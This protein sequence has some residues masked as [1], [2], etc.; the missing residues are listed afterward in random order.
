LR[1]VFP[2]RV[3]ANGALAVLADTEEGLETRRFL[4]QRVREP[5]RALEVSPD[6]AGLEGWRVVDFRPGPDGGVH[7]LEFLENAGGDWLNRLRHVNSA[8]ATTWSRQGEVDFQNTAPDRLAG[9]YTGLHQGGDGRLWLV[10]KA[11]TA[12]L[13]AIAPSDGRTLAVARLDA[14]ISNLVVSADDQA[15]YARMVERQGE[16]A[17]VLATTDLRTGRTTLGEPAS[18][19]LLDLAG[20]DARGRVY[21]RTPG[22][23]AVLDPAGRPLGRLHP[24]GAVITPGTERLVTAYGDRPDRLTLVEHDG[25][26][27]P[28]RTWSIPLDAVLGTRESGPVRLVS[29]QE[30]PRFV[31]HITGTEYLPGRLVTTT[32]D[33]RPLA[34]ED[35]PDAVS[36]ELARVES[37]IDL[38]QSAVTP[39]GAVLL[40]FSDPE[41]YRVLCLEPASA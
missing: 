23:V 37:R 35:D 10:P 14:D 2:V 3:G 40:P 24:C 21:A 28:G 19:P 32:A 41:G 36:R 6:A 17:L 4:H 39:D 15:V 25:S 29:V 13:A 20:T 16:R 26:G 33:G 18:V 31:F 5:F 8:G 27:A 30:G 12:G 9:V 34:E 7:L 11:T 38:T 1:P 22:G